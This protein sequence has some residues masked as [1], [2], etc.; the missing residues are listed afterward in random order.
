MKYI[1]TLIAG[2][3]LG[4]V[5]IAGASVVIG[6]PLKIVDTFQWDYHELFQ[7]GTSVNNND[8]VKLYDENNGAVCYI[9]LGRGISCVATSTQ[10]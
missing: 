9:Y 7:N 8:V 6:S 3:I 5:G 2:V 10:Q 4:T 1:A